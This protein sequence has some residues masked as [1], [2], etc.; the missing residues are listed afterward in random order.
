MTFFYHSF[1]HSFILKD[2]SPLQ[3]RGCARHYRQSSKQKNL[4]PYTSRDH[5]LETD[6]Q[7]RKQSSQHCDNRAEASNRRGGWQEITQG[8]LLPKGSQDLEEVHYNAT[9]NSRKSR[10]DQPRVRDLVFQAE[11]RASRGSSWSYKP[12]RWAIGQ[13]KRRRIINTEMASPLVIHP[14]CLWLYTHFPLGLESLPS[15]LS[16]ATSKIPPLRNIP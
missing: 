10:R 13:R 16:S 2:P 4:G 12:S 7:Q 1:T 9:S 3:A 6:Q 8:T 5:T 11:K 14:P 15:T